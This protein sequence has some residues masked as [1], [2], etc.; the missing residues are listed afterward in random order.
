MGSF[1][2]DDFNISLLNLGLPLAITRQ[3]VR[4]RDHLK[5]LN[6]TKRWKLESDKQRVSSNRLSDRSTI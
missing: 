6:T 3:I 5:S 2:H 1:I 4:V